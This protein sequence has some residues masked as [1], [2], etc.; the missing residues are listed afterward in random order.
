MDHRLDLALQALLR[1]KRDLLLSISG[2]GETLA[3]IV[4]AEL[5]GPDVLRSSPEAVA[6]VGLNP[7]RHQSGTS[8][9][10]VTPISKIG[11]GVLRAALLFLVKNLSDFGV[12]N[13]RTCR[14]RPWEHSSYVRL[15]NGSH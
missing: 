10:R 2:V 1:R 9:D 11:N 4:L 14:P 6:Y 7:R 5:P 15:E 12:R 8:I 13:N 3:S